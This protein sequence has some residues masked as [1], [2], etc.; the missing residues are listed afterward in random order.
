MNLWIDMLAQI[1]RTSG[2][3]TMPRI[4]FWILLILWAVGSFGW[5]DNPNV[6]RGTAGVQI[7]LF[8]VLGYY[9]FGF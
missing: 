4:I 7:I 8:A 6:V 9:L 3:L 2:D 1:V 5:R